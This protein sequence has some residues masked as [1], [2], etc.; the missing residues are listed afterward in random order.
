MQ[1]N[2]Q[3]EIQLLKNEIDHHPLVT[4]YSGDL[5]KLR[6]EIQ[7]YKTSD[8]W[9][10]KVK[11]DHELTIGLEQKYKELIAEQKASEDGKGPLTT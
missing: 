1:E 11:S 4:K 2:L 9:Q 8:D 10:T 7:I 3:A 5:Q 6:K